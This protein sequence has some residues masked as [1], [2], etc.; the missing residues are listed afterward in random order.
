MGPELRGLAMWPTNYR[1]A[2]AVHWQIVEQA[3]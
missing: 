1:T 3:V 2:K